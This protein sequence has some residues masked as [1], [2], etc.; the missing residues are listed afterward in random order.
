MVLNLLQAY[1]PIRNTCFCDTEKRK[2]KR[3]IKTINR[4]AT[5]ECVFGAEQIS[6][7]VPV[8]KCKGDKIRRVTGSKAEP[9]THLGE[10]ALL[11]NEGDDV[12][13]LDGN[14]VQGILVIRELDVLPVDVLQV[15]LLLL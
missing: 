3:A 8:C 2:F 13:R 14:H 9:K 15:V 10:F 6:H 1:F 7:R 12:H 11:V 4:Q 5:G